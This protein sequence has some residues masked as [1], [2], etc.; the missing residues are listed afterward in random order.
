MNKLIDA[1]PAIRIA[2]GRAKVKSPPLE[3]NCILEIDDLAR[4]P[5]VRAGSGVFQNRWHLHDVETHTLAVVE[6][7][8]LLG[9][10]KTLL[11]AGYLHDI[12]KPQVRIPELR[13]GMAVFSPEGH[14]YHDFP[15]HEE[16]GKEMVLA[17]DDGMF[18][19]LG[20]DKTM[21]AG[22]VGA[23]YIPMTYIKRM[24]KL[25]NYLV[26]EDALSELQR[27][28]FR[29][30]VKTRYVLDIFYADKASTGDNATDAPFIFAMRDFLAG[31][32]RTG[33][34][35]AALRRVS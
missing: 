15:K 16:K 2:E 32:I 13:E 10:D 9:A 22:I 14:A 12:G 29:L 34:L 28:L 23:H 24:K 18:R 35:Y 6:I 25:P 30:P 3:E 5:L 19:R 1:R 7:L 4:H 17:M 26:F 27:T 21:V 31:S 11:V 33:D 8:R 20:V